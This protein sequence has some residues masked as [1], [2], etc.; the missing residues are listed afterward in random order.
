MLV[1]AGALATAAFGAS[2]ASAGV[3]NVTF[4]GAGKG[5]VTSNPPGI[6]CSNVPGST[7]TTC[8]YDYGSYP[9]KI[10]V[11]ATPVTGSAFLSW[12]GT[13]CSGEANPCE[14]SMYFGTFSTT[15]TFAP[16][17]EP[18][19]VTTGGIS[20]VEFPSAKFSGSVNPN[21][22]E[23]P[24][25]SCYFEYGP[26]TAYGK[27]VPCAP[28][29]IGP[30]T[31]TVA[32][33][34][35]VGLLAADRLYHYRLVAAN[36]AW[37]RR[38]ADR[39]FTSAAA[40]ADDCANA[41]IRAQQGSIA[42]RLPDC[43]AYELVSPPSTV[44]QDPSPSAISDSGN[45]VL[46]NSAGGFADVENLNNIGT[47]YR[48]HRSEDGWATEALGGPPPAQYP[49]YGAEW[50]WQAGWWQHERPLSMWSVTTQEAATV[51]GGRQYISGYKKGPWQEVTPQLGQN[52]AN[53]ATSK[54]LTGVLV[55]STGVD[56]RPVLTDG[57]TDTHT[58]S[59]A[60]FAAVKR[61]PDGT[62]DVRQVAQV[63]GAT[64][65]P[66]CAVSLGG[67]AGSVT[68]GAVN[69]D[70]L[71][72]IVFT[73]GGSGACA[74]AAKRRV[75]VAEPFSSN[76]DAV[77][78]SASRC[79]LGTTECGSAAVVTFVGGARDASR[80]FMTTTQR[81][82][83][84]D[85]H[86]GADLYEYDFRRDPDERLQ[87]VSTGPVPPLVQGVVTVSDDGSH[88]YFVAKGALSHS[89][90]DTGEPQEGAPNLYVRI[91]G[92]VNEPARTR[93]IATLD[94]SDS[95]LWSFAS[96]AEFALTPDGRYL[97]FGSA[98]KLTS[99]DQDSLSDVYRYDAEE[100]DLRR[101]W[102]NDPAVNGSNRTSGSE[103]ASRRV[104][105]ANFANWGQNDE[106]PLP[107]IAND[108]SAISFLS[109]EAMTPGDINGQN[110]A[111]LWTAATNAVTMI[112]DGEDPRGIE[113]LGMSADGK[114]QF[115]KTIS[116]ITREHTSTS[117]AL[118][119]VRQ[120]GGFLAH[121]S[122]AP[123]TGEECQ[124]VTDAPPAPRGIGSDVSRSE[125]GS[126]SSARAVVH[127]GNLSP[128]TGSVATLRV[129]VS[130]AGRISVAGDA[131][132]KTR[133]LVPKAG[134]YAVKVALT[135]RAKRSLKNRKTLTVVG[136]VSYRPDEGR[137]TV[138]TVRVTFKQPGPRRANTE[139]KKGGR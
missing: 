97:A 93:F 138:K 94:A 76:P 54:D 31:S 38:G 61:K 130:G 102:S 126:P 101:V 20:D 19:A 108:G 91:K 44:G 118:Y 7:H 12:A 67:Q 50:D 82:L 34:A 98:A 45:D 15:V 110:D 103:F 95:F 22:N 52:A 33:S 113:S 123:C 18:L 49:F 46:I 107:Q 81:L 41:A 136:R 119:A 16:A 120:G 133:V 72:R 23:F 24:V 116:V 134:A 85:V 96:L 109:R 2:A 114:V 84:S 48:A 78:V 92:S 29:S 37:T 87:L 132:R 57:T 3:L 25:S 137:S 79:T 135:P 128:V 35:P 26:T 77:D 62:F 4:A 104:R 124:G 121:E 111:F 129:R 10:K 105:T 106:V 39:T 58:G 80:I 43:Y 30:G 99:D 14:E 9:S 100:G 89:E 40:P 56:S 71:S 65:N 90:D 64:L 27:K 122:P 127:V 21:S 59:L 13:G 86:A 53:Y 112:S 74:T 17:P 131:L 1:L 8:S 139:T 70:G 115:F 42:Q 51:G 11:F 55:Q 60:T 5:T 88:V 6:D 28:A 47:M 75:Y 73:T 32:V 117:P 66:T 69:R 68:R 83:D 36:G 125:E 63:G